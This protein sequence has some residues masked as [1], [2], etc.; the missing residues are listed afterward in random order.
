MPLYFHYLK[1]MY[2]SKVLNY[3]QGPCHPEKQKT[4]KLKRELV[5]VL[6]FPSET[7][8]LLGC[9]GTGK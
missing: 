9:P 5:R 6:Q 3:I 4:S 1:N 2:V 8:R 7:G